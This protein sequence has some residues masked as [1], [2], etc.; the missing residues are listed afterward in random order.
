MPRRRGR[1]T[2]TQENTANTNAHEHK[3][4]ETLVCPGDSPLRRDSEVCAC[5][6]QRLVDQEGKPDGIWCKM[7]PVP[8]V[9]PI[10]HIDQITQDRFGFTFDNPEDSRALTVGTQVTA[11][12]YSVETGAVVKVQGTV[13]AVDQAGAKFAGT[14]PQAGQEDLLREGTLVYLEPAD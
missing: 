5:G 1:R 11:L 12:R 7:T 4:A 3:A 8:Y 14:G 13:T 10:G 6:A 9:N 2:I